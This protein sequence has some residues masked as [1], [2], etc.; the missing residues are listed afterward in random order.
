M[1]ILVTGASGF[2]GGYLTKMLVEAGHNVK[3]L[4]RCHSDITRLKD[5]D[6]EIISGDIR[7]IEDLEKIMKGCEQVYHGAAQRTQ[8]KIPKKDYYSV[9]VD[10]SRNIAQTAI[11]TDVKRLVYLSTAGVYG[12]IKQVKVDE[13]TPCY[14]NTYYRTTKWLG[15]KV[16]LSYYQQHNLPVVIARLSGVCGAGSLNWLGLVKAIATP[17]FR[18]IGTGN[19]EY[20]LTDIQDIITGLKL[21]A[22]KPN[23][24]GKTYNIAAKESMKVKNIVNLIAENLNIVQPSQHLPSL[25]YH[26]F[27]TMTEWFYT[28]FKRQLPGHH[29]YDMFVGNRS[30]NISK[31]I[32]E[33][34]YSPQILPPAAIKILIN[35]YQEKDYV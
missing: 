16:L 25:P 24:E 17:N 30:L 14:P 19:N 1:R 20:H 23:I 21:C 26:T 35:W 13:N 32:A 11:K 28:T 2:I 5:L 3:T 31:A 7:N 27:S 10:G 29:R 8:P 9:N 4:V 12:T 33:L 22:D 18:L 34:D 6:V 15:E